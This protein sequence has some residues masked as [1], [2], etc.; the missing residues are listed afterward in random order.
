MTLLDCLYLVIGVQV[1]L[2]LLPYLLLLYLDGLQLGLQLRLHLVEGQPR[3]RLVG[4]QLAACLVVGVRL[5]SWSVL[6]VLGLTPR[7]VLVGLQ[8]II[9]LGGLWLTCCI[10]V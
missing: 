3:I 9:C 2:D 4:L 5:P 6:S 1:L 10:G 7:L 8:A